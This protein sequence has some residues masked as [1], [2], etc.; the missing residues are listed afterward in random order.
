MKQ[1][2]ILLEQ[3][4]RDHSIINSNIQS[5]NHFVD[6]EMQAIIEE[7]REIEPTII[8]QNVDEFKIRL[9]EIWV[10]RPGLNRPEEAGPSG[11]SITEADGSK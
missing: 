2:T 4:F 1:S 5:F 9:D 11:P 3:F 7:N 6:H 8:P 10:S